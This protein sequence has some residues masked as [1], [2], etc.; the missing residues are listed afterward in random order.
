MLG[1]RDFQMDQHHLLLKDDHTRPYICSQKEGVS[2]TN[3]SISSI[4]W[5]FM[6]HLT[7][8]HNVSIC[9]VMRKGPSTSL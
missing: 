8:L 1:N 7:T 4:V 5:N 3:I 9:V 2:G 6:F